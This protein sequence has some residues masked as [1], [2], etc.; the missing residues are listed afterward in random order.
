[1]LD[2]LHIENIAVA[3]C[4]DIDFDSGFSVLTGETGAGKSIIIDSI[5]I[6]LGA[7]TSKELIRHGETRAQVSA[8]FSNL[9]EGVYSYLDECEIPY[10]RGDSLV[11]SRSFS[12]DGKNIIKINSRPATQAQ[13]KELGVH[14]ISIHGQN[15]NQSFINKSNHVLLLDE[16]CQNEELI[17]KYFD[18]YQKLNQKKKQI[19]ELFDEIKKIEASADLIKFQIKEISSAKLKDEDE[20]EKLIELRN[21]LKNAEKILKSSGAV[22]KLLFKNESGISASVLIEKSIDA[23][24]KI[25]DIDPSID[26]MVEKLKGFK[27]ELEDIAETTK[28][29]CSV[30]SLENPEAELDKIEDRL[31]VISRM[32]KK[33]GPTLADVIKFKAELEGKLV[34]WQ[35]S[36]NA[37]EALKSEY[38][39]L[40]AEACVVAEAIHD[41]RKNGAKELSRAVKETLLYLDMPKVQFE[42][43]V[44]EIMRDGTPVLSSNGYDDVEFMIATNAG[45]NLS[46]MNKIVSGGELARIMLAIKSV[47]SGN[48]SQTI[49]FDEI[50]TGVSGSTSQKIGVKLAKI[51]NSM[52]T[53]C[54]THSAQIAALAKNHLLIKKIESEGRAVTTVVQ[55][56]TE[57][58]IDEIARIIGGI[59]L[60]ES[61]YE[62]ARVLLNQRDE[63]LSD[64]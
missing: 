24:N 32:Q 31:N 18:Y 10:D 26:T 14:L 44:N 21:K 28:D 5:N 57:K 62:A 61:Q 49:I 15:E 25:S 34:T 6:I 17:E 7:K 41:S 55:L 40:H 27:S 1:M 16:Y 33:Y 35:D 42:I 37:L 53:I 51:A 13:L 22:Y 56:D 47:I 54:V 8:S 63:L 58:R 30:D 23:L 20:E 12:L 60:R 38:K 52:Q 2:F 43:V 4:L 48:K 11:I 9:S 36:E 3:K 45:D 64:I 19:A 46:K 29:L 50:D 59:D 39:A